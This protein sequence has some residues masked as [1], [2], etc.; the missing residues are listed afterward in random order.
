L[1]SIGVKKP[2]IFSL[3]KELVDTLISKGVNVNISRSDFYWRFYCLAYWARD[4]VYGLK[5]IYFLF[6]KK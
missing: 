4:V 3:L 1:Y 2:L 6:R 5:R